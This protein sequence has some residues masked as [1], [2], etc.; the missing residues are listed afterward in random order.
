[1]TEERRLL[2]EKLKFEQESSHS[3]VRQLE[4]ELEKMSDKLK[5][6]QESLLQL[7][8]EKEQLYMENQ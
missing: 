5:K 7:Q 2:Q 1:L 3:T 4:A 8:E 6:K